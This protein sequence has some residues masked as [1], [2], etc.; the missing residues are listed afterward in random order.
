MNKGTQLFL[1]EVLDKDRLSIIENLKQIKDLGFYL[2]GG[3]ALAL[4]FGHRESIDFDF[5]ISEN[6]DTDILFKKCLDIFDGFEIKKTFEEKNTLYINVNGVKISFFTYKYK[7]I[8]NFIENE[9]FN[10]ASIQ[11]IGCMKLWAIQN[12]ATNKDYV[13]LYFIIKEIGLHNLINNFFLKFGQVVTDTYLLKSLIYFEDVE[14][15]KLIIKDKNISFDFIKT[16]LE[17]FV[18]KY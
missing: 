11:D 6:I 14:A 15:E 10:I 12:R 17:K 16:N 2:A 13:D 9:Y 8:G 1:E 7:N 18:K 4:I 5:F 3:T